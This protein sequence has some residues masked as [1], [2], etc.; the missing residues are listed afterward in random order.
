MREREGERRKSEGER[1][2]GGMRGGTQRE[3]DY[4]NALLF[5][6]LLLLFSRPLGKAT[7]KKRGSGVRKGNQNDFRKKRN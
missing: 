3:I 7:N 2:E 4:T 6:L 5:L 1:I